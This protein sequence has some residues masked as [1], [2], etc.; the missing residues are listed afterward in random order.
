MTSQ[1]VQQFLCTLQQRLSMLF[2]G[3]TA[4]KIVRPLGGSDPYVTYG[5]LGLSE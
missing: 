5:L 4:L 2:N 3:R 1:L